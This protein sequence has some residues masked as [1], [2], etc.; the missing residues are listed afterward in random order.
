MSDDEW[1]ELQRKNAHLYTGKDVEFLA[2]LDEE[3][4]RFKKRFPVW[5]S[6]ETAFYQEDGSILLVVNTPGDGD[7]PRT[8]GNRAYK[9]GD[10]SYQDIFNRHKFNERTDTHHWIVTNR[11]DEIGEGWG[12]M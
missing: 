4:Q 3:H 9:P 12:D 5:T 2:E 7:I 11:L 1:K 8:H 10:E 6:V